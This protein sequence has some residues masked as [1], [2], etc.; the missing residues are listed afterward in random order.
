MGL[1]KISL[2][3]KTIEELSKTSKSLLS[4]KSKT[5]VEELFSQPE[6]KEAETILF[7]V[8][9]R[10]EVETHEAIKIA[11]A[12]GKRVAVPVTDLKD[13][14][15]ELAEIKSFEELEEK[16]SGIMEPKEI[17]EIE[18]KEI[19]LVIVPGLAFDEEKNRL[20]RG[21]GCYDW[22]LK[23]LKCSSVAL[24]FEC[25]IVEKVPVDGNDEKIG[26]IVTEERIIK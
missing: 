23:Q 26:K 16:E 1:D 17:K 8:S 20:G 15:L 18:P 11:L 19:D 4:K 24:A 6:F 9:F 22:L 2:R 7:Y 14:E 12:R 10:Q 3:K 25:Q 21:A 13:Y 5:I